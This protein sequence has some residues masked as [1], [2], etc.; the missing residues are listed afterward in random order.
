MKYSTAYVV[1]LSRKGKPWQARLKFKDEDG[2]W[3][4]KT[5]LLPEANGKREAQKLADAWLDEMNRQ[6]EEELKEKAKLV[7]ENNKLSVVYENYLEMQY[8][9]GALEKS[10]YVNNLYYYEEYIKPFL[11]DK[12]FYCIDREDII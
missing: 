1:Q 2:K 5:K 8:S 12:N 11:G 9:T 7:D 3:K 6:A 4:E 10:T